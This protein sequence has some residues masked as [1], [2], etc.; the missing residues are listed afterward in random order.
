MHE[1]ERY[2]GHEF[3]SQ[4]A[5]VQFY[6]DRI[7]NNDTGLIARAP[8]FRYQRRR[9]Q[10]DVV[11]LNKQYFNLFMINIVDFVPG[12]RASGIHLKTAVQRDTPSVL[13]AGRHR[14]QKELLGERGP[15]RDR[16]TLSGFQA[17]D[18]FRKLRV[19]HCDFGVL[20]HVHLS[21]SLISLIFRPPILVIVFD[22]NNIYRFV[23]VTLMF[24]TDFLELLLTTIVAMTFS[25]W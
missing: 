19:H 18:E 24:F 6:F 17:G 15:R 8:T 4:S 1:F 20:N 14:N 9:R 7:R 13:V 5:A 10:I 12:S 22:N 25:P 23:R 21:L 16:T 11:V 2:I 3:A